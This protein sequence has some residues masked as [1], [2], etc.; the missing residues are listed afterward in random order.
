ME[1]T[2][3][4]LSSRQKDLGVDLKTKQRDFHIYNNNSNILFKSTNY[5]ILYN[6]YKSKL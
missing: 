5:N 1:L 6:N 4:K 2:K 3:Y